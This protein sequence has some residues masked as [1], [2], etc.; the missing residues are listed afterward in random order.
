MKASVNAGGPR[1]TE[2][3][4]DR[5]VCEESGSGRGGFD[6][7]KGRQWNEG[8]RE[9]RRAAA[10]RSGRSCLRADRTFGGALWTASGVLPNQRNGAARV[11][12]QEKVG[13]NQA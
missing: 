12:T 7:R 13:N 8:Q 9:C 6:Q 11:A 2:V 5:G 4:A 1:L 3:G 10:D